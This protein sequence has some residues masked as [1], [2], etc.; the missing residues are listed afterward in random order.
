MPIP[1]NRILLQVNGEFA[2]AGGDPY[3]AFL[4]TTTPAE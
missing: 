1:M 4:T 2:A 3:A